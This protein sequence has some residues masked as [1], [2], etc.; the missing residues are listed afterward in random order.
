M[1]S[2]S[3]APSNPVARTWRRSAWIPVKAFAP[4]NCDFVATRNA[5]PYFAEVGGVVAGSPQT[6]KLLN[7]Q[8][9]FVTYVANRTRQDRFFRL[10]LVH[11]AGIQASFEQ[12]GPPVTVTTTQIFA[13]SSHTRSVWAEPSATNPRGSIRV[14]IEEVDSLDQ[15]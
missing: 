10:T 3:G 1:P 2:G 14:V 11:A 12:F 13:N 9:A 15:L 5:N 7:I 6:F 8:R 4:L